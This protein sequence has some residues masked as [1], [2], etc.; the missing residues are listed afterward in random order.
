MPSHSQVFLR[1]CNLCIHHED[2]PC[3]HCFTAFPSVL[4]I[5]LLFLFPF[6]SSHLIYWLFSLLSWF[7]QSSPVL[8]SDPPS[9][10]PY[11]I[12]LHRKMW[13]ACEALRDALLVLG[14]GIDGGKDSLSMAAKVRQ[15]SSNWL[16]FFSPF[17]SSSSPLLLFFSSSFIPHP[18]PFFLPPSP[19]SCSPYQCISSLP[20]SNYS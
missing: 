14:P 16:F 20:H 10:L 4:L 2:V 19:R 3:T 11:Y 17:Y 12:V 7:N 5:C 9:I 18:R 1:M 15:W 8:F 6:F 13:E